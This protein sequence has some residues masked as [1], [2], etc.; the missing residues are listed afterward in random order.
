MMNKIK[1]IDIK[2]II[3]E[4]FQVN[5]MS[6][7]RRRQHVYPRAVF[8]K[9]ARR[10]TDATIQDLADMVNLKNHATVI[11]AINSTFHDAMY[12]NKY[13]NL[14][15]KLHREYSKV[16]S[17]ERENQMLKVQVRELTEL[18]DFYRNKVEELGVFN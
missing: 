11:N 3:E 16:P 1:A 17:V 4:E 2:D 5:L 10:H 13:K 18:I 15:N 7:S 12:E 6:Q 9:L 8:F 14:Y